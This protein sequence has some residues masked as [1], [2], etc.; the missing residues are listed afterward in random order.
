MVDLG[1]IYTSGGLS[2]ASWSRHILVV[3]HAIL[4]LGHQFTSGRVIVSEV[5]EIT[6]SDFDGPH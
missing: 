3:L 1:W 2:V 4:I 5:V 6:G